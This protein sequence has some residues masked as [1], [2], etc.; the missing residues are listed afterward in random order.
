M[1]H[2]TWTLHRQVELLK[3]PIDEPSN[4][5]GLIVS[6]IAGNSQTTLSSADHIPSV[7]QTSWCRPE[8]IV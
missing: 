2:N 8:L 4:A 1:A 7:D 3:Q 5:N 6:E